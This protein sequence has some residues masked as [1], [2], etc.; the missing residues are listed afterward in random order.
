MGNIAKKVKEG[1]AKS[2]VLKR[3]IFGILSERIYHSDRFEGKI[4]T[5]LARTGLFALYGD[6]F[7]L[8]EKRILITGSSGEGKSNLARY[9]EKNNPNI[10]QHFGTDYVYL[11]ADGNQEPSLLQIPKAYEGYMG[12]EDV[13]RLFSKGREKFIPLNLWI[14]LTSHDD[15][16]MGPKRKVTPNAYREE[17]VSLAGDRFTKENIK[18]LL[19]QRT[20]NVPYFGILKPYGYESDPSIPRIDAWENAEKH[21]KNKRLRYEKDV[22][23]TAKAVERLIKGET[24]GFSF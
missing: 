17:A 1:L 19:G 7:S 16:F 4:Y 2:S 20:A 12:L 22:S 6:A 11:F 5:E 8:D 23:R 15:N 13:I 21:A 3:N 10:Y 9:F 14:H 18:K 24:R